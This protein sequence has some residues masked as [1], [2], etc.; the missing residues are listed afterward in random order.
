MRTGMDAMRH[1]GHLSDH[2]KAFLF[3]NFTKDGF[4]AALRSGTL[5]D[6]TP[7]SE[8]PGQ[9]FRD[10][11]GIVRDRHGPFWPRDYG[12]L[13]PTPV[14]RRLSPPQDEPLFDPLDFCECRKGS[15]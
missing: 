5:P 15:G 1:F 12:P 7:L 9:R 3:L 4:C 2:E 10:R 11:Y 8:M 14:H 6:G 13:H